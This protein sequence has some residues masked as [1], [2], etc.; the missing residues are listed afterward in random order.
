MAP[1]EA[2]KVVPMNFFKK[3][4][5]LQVLMLQHNAGLTSSH[6]YASEPINWPFDLTGI[7]FWTGNDER[8]QIYAIGN[9]VGWWLCVLG[10]SIFLGVIGADM[11]ARRRGVEP[12]EEHLR[13]RLYNNTGFFL[14]S[15]LCHYLPFFLMSRQLFIHHYL[16]AHVSSAL[17]TG[18]VLNF[19]LNESIDFP[20]S[21]AGERTRLRPR[22]RALVKRRSMV[23]LGVLSVFFVGMFLFLAPLTYG[24]PG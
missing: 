23:V 3:F 16:P 6:P 12:I 15:W 14:I 24:Y 4:F 5:E 22:V 17:V 20:V 21:E 9:P 2:K 7:S 18:S 19:L 13:N 10:V 8:Q 11:L 1:P